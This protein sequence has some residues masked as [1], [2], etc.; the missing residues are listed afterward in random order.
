M[1]VTSDTLKAAK[2]DYLLARYEEDE[3]VMEPTCFCGKALEE[4]YFCKECNRECDC[5]FIACEDA[6]ALS[7]VEKLVHGNPTFKNFKVSLLQK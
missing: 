2:Q 4:D 3:L 1:A 7:L 6:Q 5:T